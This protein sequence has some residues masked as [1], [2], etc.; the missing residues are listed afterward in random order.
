MILL[1]FPSF[2]LKLWTR[3]LQTRSWSYVRPALAQIPLFKDRL[4]PLPPARD[5]RAFF[6]VREA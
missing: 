3:K 2:A 5:V 1:T 6:G 4:D